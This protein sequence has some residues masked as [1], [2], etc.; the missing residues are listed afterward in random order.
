MSDDRTWSTRHNLPIA[1]FI[2]KE[3][4]PNKKYDSNLDAIKASPVAR[5]L[6]D[7]LYAPFL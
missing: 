5:E 1:T 6:E 3:K 7:L 4:N 2:W